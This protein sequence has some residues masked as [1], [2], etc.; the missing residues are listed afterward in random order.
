MR[1]SYLCFP[2]ASSLRHVTPRVLCAD[3]GLLILLPPAA[4]TQSPKK[5]PPP[6]VYE[7]LP[8]L[9]AIQVPRRPFERGSQGWRDVGVPSTTAASAVPAAV[10]V[11]KPRTWWDLDFVDPGGQRQT[12]DAPR[13]T[14]ST[15]VR[16]TVQQGVHSLVAQAQV[17]Q[18][19]T[20]AD[21]NGDASDPG[22]GLYVPHPPL[23]TAANLVRFCRHLLSVLKDG[24]VALAGG[25]VA[26]SPPL[27][28]AAAA[29]D[30]AA[31]TAPRLVYPAH[32]GDPRDRRRL[33]L[34]RDRASAVRDDDI[35]TGRARRRRDRRR[36]NGTDADDEAGGD[37]D[38]GSDDV[39]D[40]EDEPPLTVRYKPLICE[41]S[42]L[43]L[44]STLSATMDIRLAGARFHDHVWFSREDWLASAIVSMYGT[45]CRR[46]KVRSG[47]GE[48]VFVC[49]S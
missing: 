48:C 39:D 38:G 46:L 26:A 32:A 4:N 30:A 44:A 27:P 6:E 24:A 20:R 7:E 22:N 5:K 3:G 9:T 10:I 28:D 16:S 49:G 34:V 23:V 31:A 17:G 12:G 40:E 19:L 2:P 8:E 21:R 45:Y 33:L 15:T 36:N 35:E 37:D 1:A 43:P 25:G 11:S 13:Q 29:H 41:P 42:E 47:G 14:T 18:Q